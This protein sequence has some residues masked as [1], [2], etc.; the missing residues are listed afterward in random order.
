MTCARC[1]AQALRAWDPALISFINLGN[2]NADLDNAN[3]QAHT[4][5]ANAPVTQRSSLIDV[6]KASIT[7]DAREGGKLAYCHIFGETSFEAAEAHVIRQ[8]SL[9]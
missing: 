6:I 9:M 7:K 3:V 1:N 4:V 5:D 2:A 8:L